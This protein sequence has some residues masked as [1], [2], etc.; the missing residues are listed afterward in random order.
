MY[1]GRDKQKAALSLTLRKSRESAFKNSLSDLSEL[2]DSYELNSSALSPSE[3]SPKVQENE[4]TITDQLQQLSISY[5]QSYACHICEKSTESS[6]VA[7]LHFNLCLKRW[8][9]K[10]FQLGEEIMN[11]IDASN[12]VSM[13]RRRLFSDAANRMIAA[14]LDPRLA[15]IVRT[16][17]PTAN[18]ASR[19]SGLEQACLSDTFEKFCVILQNELKNPDSRIATRGSP[20]KS[21]FMIRCALR[22]RI[23]QMVESNKEASFDY[24]QTVDLI[25]TLFFAEK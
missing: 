21:A 3:A 15:K 8:V 4:F 16:N 5:D 25:E 6:S 17:R 12:R 10:N 20:T 23:K 19:K 11:A 2:T 14:A 7:K 22:L 24:I 1:I 18:L 13:K 9:E